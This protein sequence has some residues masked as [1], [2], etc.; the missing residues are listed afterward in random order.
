MTSDPGGT[1][2]YQQ[3]SA[4]IF[5]NLSHRKIE[6]VCKIDIISGIDPSMDFGAEG[7]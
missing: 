5:S 1:Y 4:K 7:G 6:A 3:L 2:L